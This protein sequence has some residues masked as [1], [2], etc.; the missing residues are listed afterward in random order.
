M[1]VRS[2]ADEVFNQPPPYEDV[3]LFGSDAP[4]RGRWCQTGLRTRLRHWKSSAG[5]GAPPKYSSKR[6]CAIAAAIAP[7]LTLAHAVVSAVCDIA[8]SAEQEHRV[9]R[10]V[11]HLAPPPSRGRVA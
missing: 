3:D 7:Q 6:E 8:S 4:L 11:T 1:A 9:H 2:D 10:S 5:A